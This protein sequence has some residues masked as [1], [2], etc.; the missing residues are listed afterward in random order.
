MPPVVKMSVEERLAFKHSF[1]E[2]SLEDWEEEDE[3]S[4]HKRRREPQTAFPEIYGEEEDEY[5]DEYDDEEG[6]EDEEEIDFGAIEAQVW[7]D[8]YE[9]F[10]LH[11]QYPESGT[12][13]NGGGSR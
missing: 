3:Q 7:R 4:R 12:R 8:M 2:E 1:E 11:T 9:R 6:D 13:G 10:L 5:D